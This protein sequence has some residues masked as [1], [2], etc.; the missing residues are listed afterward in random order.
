MLEEL[1]D[2]FFGVNI[3][4]MQDT[5]YADYVITCAGLQSDRVAQMTGCSPL[6]KIMPFRGDYLY[7]KPEKHHLV[8]TNI[9]PVP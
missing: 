2:R 3:L 1:I 4:H 8:S 6:P 9:Y 7:L 5:L